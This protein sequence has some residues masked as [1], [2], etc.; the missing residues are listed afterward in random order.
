M[1]LEKAPEIQELLSQ[2]KHNK[3]NIRTGGVAE[4]FRGILYSFLAS[5]TDSDLL[6]ITSS[7]NIYALYAEMAS[8]KEYFDHSGDIM[9][10]PEDDSLIY[11]EL[12]A[13]REISKARANV[14][15]RI[16]KNGR[17]IV[18]TDINAMA[19][20]IPGPDMVKKQVLKLKTADELDTAELTAL[21]DENKYERVLKVEN[22]FEYSIR[23]S[24]IDIFPPD[25]EYPVRIELYG[26]L[27]E[28]L[29]YFSIETYST[30]KQVDSLELMLF[31]PGAKMK[32]QTACILDYFRVRDTVIVIDDEDTVKREIIE[33][34]AK[35]EKYIENTDV[36]D[37]IFSARSVF[38]KMSPFVKMRSSSISRPGAVNFRLKDNP[39]FKRDIKM[40]ISYLHE[41]R[42]KQA[43]VWII[44]DNDGE[45]EHLKE[46]IRENGEALAGSVGFI[47]AN[48]Y[49]G[50]YMPSAG[51]CFISNREIF[52]RYKGRVAAKRARAQKQL[53][54]IKHYMELKEGDH[55]VHRDHGIGVFEGVKTLTF[56]DI[57]S[58]FI[59]LR[60]AGDD[61]LYLPIYK[62]SAIDRYIGSEGIPV[63][64]KLG[65]GAWRRTKEDIQ[66]QIR[67]MAHELLQISAKREI[68]GGIRYP[69]DDREQLAFE[70][71]FIYEETP[72]QERAIEEVKSD[73]EREKPMDRLVCGDAGFGKTEV[74]MRAAFK[75]V[76]A[77]RQVLVLTATTLLAQ[78][79]YM[80]FKERMADYPIRV[81][82]LSRLTKSADRSEIMAQTARGRVD[83]LI[84]TSA[85]LNK[86]L[87]FDSLGLVIIDEEQHFGV[88]AKEYLRDRHPDADMLT[89]TATPIP[90]TLYFAVS[91]IRSMSTIS[92]PPPGKRPIETIIAEERMPAIKEIILREILRKG[93]V[94]YVHNNI[95][96]IFK[97]TDD[98]QKALPGVRFRA[99]HG[100]MNKIQ[101]E[102]LMIDFLKRK[103]DVLVTTT[104]IESGLD[105]PDVNTIIVS[106]A[107]RF[108][109]SQL[110]QLR[111]RVGRRDRQAYAYM[112]VKDAKYMTGQARER[113]HALESYND[114][115]A[116]F[117]IAM[118]DLEIRGA[119]SILGTKQHGNIEK[120]GF[121]MYCRMLEESVALVKGQ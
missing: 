27:A 79:H 20:K 58:D 103:F 10:Y 30:T 98:L 49:A 40:F 107:D 67:L 71:A 34:I 76:N 42:E 60:Y 46:L 85:V 38:K 7:E 18:I 106:G 82:M 101:L 92:T 12:K 109:L 9:F 78:Q 35:V 1:Q 29:R 91:G 37:N 23:G 66:N 61:K 8:L 100:R 19:E 95:S 4:C 63:L 15:E 62:I 21:L 99:A 17:K 104:I 97:L 114:P 70:H 6:I 51:L 55:I 33:K 119:G 53:K 75:A 36:K 120:I 28:S 50:C 31:N 88:K 69:A 39:V 16:F 54:P 105:M 72:D 68:S 110:Y 56:D 14:Y 47:N 57:T 108:G 45:T 59:Y 5:Q 26:N 43:R 86:N 81:E 24:I 93:Q 41:L 84:G 64:S 52:D 13:S 94:F 80:T 22:A 118:R 44:S 113:L 11:H 48:S 90:R 96:T 73:M 74:A 117:K 115:G 83:I 112:L 121:E 25:S 77:D 116:G 87:E 111:G 3:R 65:A 2:L 32:S 89:L 102:R